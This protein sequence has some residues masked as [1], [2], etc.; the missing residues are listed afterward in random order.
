MKKP[1]GKKTLE[2][3]R[4]WWSCDIAVEKL[5]SY[6]LLYVF[7]LLRRQTDEAQSLTLHIIY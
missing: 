3:M 2:L 1:R 5:L 7:M 6:T 4:S